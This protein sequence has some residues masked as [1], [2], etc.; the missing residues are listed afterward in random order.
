MGRGRWAQGLALLAL[1]S[2][3]AGCAA[4]Q[5][6][7]KASVTPSQLAAASPAVLDGK[8][9]IGGYSLWMQCAGSGSPTVVLDAGLGGG[10]SFWTSVVPDLVKT[11]RV[12]VY[13]RAGIEL[14]DV[15]PGSPATSVGAMADELATLLDVTHEQGGT[16]SSATPSVA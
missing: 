7:T 13:D 16:L 8:F 15:R 6:S 1:I 9:D 10:S 2:I 12:C 11:S 5:P 4:A 14:S 3:V